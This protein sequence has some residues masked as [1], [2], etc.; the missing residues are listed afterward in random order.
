[1]QELLRLQEQQKG[2]AVN[3]P[4]FKQN[5]DNTV[6]MTAALRDS[7]DN[8]KKELKQTQSLI[9]NLKD[10]R[11][12]IKQ[13][14]KM[15]MNNGM[16]ESVARQVQ[17]A[18]N[19]APEEKTLK[20]VLFGKDSKE[21]VEDK[22][23]TK[24]LGF[25]KTPTMAL[26]DWADKKD[27]KKAYEKEKSDYVAN[28]IKHDPNTY[29][30]ANLKGGIDSEEGKAAATKKAESD[31][32]KI[33]AKEAELLKVQNKMDS[34]TGAGYNP[35]EKDIKS[36]NTLAGQL[37]ELDPRKQRTEPSEE[38]TEARVASDNSS[39]S[40]IT[41]QTS[42]GATA[43]ESLKVQREQ[44]DVLKQ[45]L[46]T[47][48]TGGG[49]AG[50]GFGLGDAVD[51][52]GNRGGKPAGKPGAPAGKPGAPAGKPGIG[53]KAMNFLR[54]TGGKVLG[55]VG[56]VGFGAYTSYK[57]FTD[58]NEQQALKNQEIDAALQSGQIDEKQA[59]E[60]KKENSD[61][62]DVK[63]GEAVG[64]GTGMAA[65]GL[66]GAAGGAAVGGAIGSAFFGVGA[67]PG[68]LIGGAIGG[69]GGSI[70]GSTLGKKAGGAIVEGYQGVRDFFGRKKEELQQSKIGQAWADR[71]KGLDAGVGV[72]QGE[73]Q[74][75]AE[76]NLERGMKT[77]GEG[78]AT[79]E[80]K[81][82]KGITNEK[83]AMGSGFLG[84]LLASKGT[85][86]EKFLTQT[87]DTKGSETNFSG[88]LGTRKEGGMF[89]KD[90]YT[91]IDTNN[92]DEYKVEKDTFMKAKE[93]AA[94][95]GDSAAIYK[96]IDNDPIVKKKIQAG[97][98]NAEP[99]ITDELG[100]IAAG[101]AQPAAEPKVVDAAAT[102]PTA[103]PA[104]ETPPLQESPIVE[105]SRNNEEIRSDV[106]GGGSTIINAPNNSVT[107]SG[108]SQPDSSSM[109][110]PIRN[111]E[112]SV[113]RYIDS[114]YAV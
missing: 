59:E 78:N 53:S 89:S 90:E 13:S 5:R 44:L 20:Q 35:L 112:S 63:K 39:K 88:F 48:G 86:T 93:I 103:T 67:V 28:A 50:G 101:M 104:M 108:G 51:L 40:L 98:K 7:V 33:K 99:P 106:E 49:R 42:I 57:G 34:A 111:P 81:L 82:N 45:I 100:H 95:G 70:A 85:Q 2:S 31:F 47:G 14:I 3:D 46:G 77:D 61:T 62:T 75:T 79:L 72:R 26:Y 23:W 38:Q 17:A 27:K 12:T 41:A 8:T 91:L 114:K 4:V 110:S 29:R 21:D 80:S 69:I 19:K 55:A 102:T 109:R 32:E 107:N 97:L 94:K 25:S 68:A 18:G 74:I 43:T 64:E 15:S 84:R 9:D 96:L 65:G 30:T 56:A 24:K 105:A 10:L 11:D 73:Q 16:G 1:M 58:A 52:L 76:T 66:A 36:R 37:T 71:D 83:T 60:L 22:S 6:Q 92:Y 54:G 87:A 113:S